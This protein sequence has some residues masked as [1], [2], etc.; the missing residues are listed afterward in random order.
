MGSFFFVKFCLNVF[1][2]FVFMCRLSCLCIMW[3]NIVI[4]LGSESYFMLGSSVSVCV[5]KFMIV[6]LCWISFDMCG[7]SILMVIVVE[8]MEG[9]GLDVSEGGRMFL[10]GCFGKR[11]EG[12]MRFFLSVFL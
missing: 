2:F 9:S 5:K 12:G 11:C 8:G 6:R 7:C 4:F 3:L 10:C 1:R